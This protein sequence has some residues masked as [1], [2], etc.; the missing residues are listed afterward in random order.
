L[1]SLNHL[2]STLGLDVSQVKVKVVSSSISTSVSS[3]TNVIGVSEM[4]AR[5][6]Q[7]CVIKRHLNDAM[8]VMHCVKSF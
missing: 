3:L 8:L 4:M 6:P 2:T 1:S 7:I 5:L